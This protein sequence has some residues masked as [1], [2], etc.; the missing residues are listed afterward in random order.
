MLR[1]GTSPGESVCKLFLAYRQGPSEG[2]SCVEWLHERLSSSRVRLAGGEEVDVRIYWDKRSKP[3]LSAL[4]FVAEAMRRF[5]A[6]ED[7]EPC[8]LADEA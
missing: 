6:K 7:A 1:M 3:W 2:D 4:P 8:S 5:P